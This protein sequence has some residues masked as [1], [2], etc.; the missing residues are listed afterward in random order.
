MIVKAVTVNP[1]DIIE[2][3]QETY[4]LF[5]QTNGYSDSPVVRAGFYTAAKQI[6][7]EEPVPHE[8]AQNEVLRRLEMLRIEAINE[9]LEYIEM[10]FDSVAE[11]RLLA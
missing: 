9:F 3:F 11:S 6:V 4:R 1:H 8:E 7:I 2:D 5:L 10:T